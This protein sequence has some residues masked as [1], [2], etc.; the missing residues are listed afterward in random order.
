MNGNTPV[1]IGSVL[2]C[3]LLPASIGLSTS[4]PASGSVV[5]Q[6]I[7]S[8]GLKNFSFGITSNETATISI[9]RYIDNLGTIPVGA[10]ITGSLTANTAGY[11]DS[12]DSV[13]YQSFIITVSNSTST[14]ATISNCALLLQAN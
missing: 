3:Y 5:S 14:A 10:A 6:A 12:V 13:P 2:Q 8:G 7:I 11:V 4:L 9:Q 1:D